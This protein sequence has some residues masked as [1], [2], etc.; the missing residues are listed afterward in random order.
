MPITTLTPTVQG[1]DSDWLLGAG[2]SKPAAVGTNDADTS[3]I[4]TTTA[5]AIKETYEFDNLPVSALSVSLVVE[6]VVNRSSAAVNGPSGLRIRE[7]ATGLDGGSLLGGASY[8]T[9]TYT[10]ASNAIAAAWTPA[11]VNSAQWGVH[12][13]MDVGEESNLRV[14]Q[15]F[16]DVTWVTKPP[17]LVF[18]IGQW[19]GPLVG[20]GLAEM[21]RLATELYRRSGS[22]IAPDEYELAWREMREYRAPRF[23][24]RPASGLFVPA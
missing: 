4:V 23:F 14:T 8:S 2:A 15:I 11:L 3:Y 10:W 7:G 18:L 5:G 19:L 6:S 16:V 17:G 9:S 21:Q 22:R 13:D 24:F 20:V 12:G 1:T